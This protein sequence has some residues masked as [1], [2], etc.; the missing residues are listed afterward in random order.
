MRTMME[1]TMLDRA[2]MKR[3]MIE[4]AMIEK[5]L[6]PAMASAGAAP[7]LGPGPQLD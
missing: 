7:R 4:R 2:L 3:A 6:Q 5:T 1:Q